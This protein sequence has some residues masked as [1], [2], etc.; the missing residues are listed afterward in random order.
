MFLVPQG[1]TGLLYIPMVAP[2]VRQSISH[3][4]FLERRNVIFAKIIYKGVN[5]GSCDCPSIKY[6]V[7]NSTKQFGSKRVE[8]RGK[9]HVGK[10]GNL[11]TG[12][13]QNKKSTRVYKEVDGLSL[14]QIKIVSNEV[15]TPIRTF[16]NPK[17]VAQFVWNGLPP[18]GPSTPTDSESQ[19]S[20]AWGLQV[21]SNGILP[22]DIG[23]Y[24][25]GEYKYNLDAG[26][27]GKND[28]AD[29]IAAYN[30]YFSNGA[31]ETENKPSVVPTYLC[32][33]NNF[34][35]C[36]RPNCCD[37]EPCDDREKSK[38]NLHFGPPRHVESYA[39]V[40]DNGEFPFYYSPI[41]IPDSHTI[42]DVRLCAKSDDISFVH[43]VQF[44]LDLPEG[45]S[46]VGAISGDWF[47]QAEV[48]PDGRTII[49]TGGV[50][51]DS[52][53]DVVP[54]ITGEAGPLTIAQVMVT[55]VLKEKLCFSCGKEKKTVVTECCPDAPEWRPYEIYDMG[56][57]VK[58]IKLFHKE[59]GEEIDP[60]LYRF[61]NYEKDYQGNPVYDQNGRRSGNLS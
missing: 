36:S 33:V 3:L 43:S 44:E 60:S 50:M 20:T 12:V 19:F 2:L 8:Y 30:W 39:Q 16:P 13:K 4:F 9:T 55:P 59:T 21:G 56:D 37:A 18:G 54:A 53:G 45:T 10:D 31:F 5:F 14:C 15:R 47:D 57:K 1:I 48:Q 27:D 61:L 51:G 29:F 49:V 34:N 52:Q 46:I 24:T 25:Y 58:G 35:N 7:E 6:Y 32:N 42:V 23:N 11:Y 26:W 22:S 28:I 38:L 17:Q 40:G 41:S